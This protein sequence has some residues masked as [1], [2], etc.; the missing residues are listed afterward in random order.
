MTFVEMEREL[1]LRLF[2]RDVDIY[3]YTFLQEYHVANG[4]FSIHTCFPHHRDFF[5]I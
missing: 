5:K 4:V 1:A 3:K 2:F